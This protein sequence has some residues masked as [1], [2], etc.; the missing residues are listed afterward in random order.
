MNASAVS[1]HSNNIFINEASLQIGIT[2]DTIG[3]RA[4][5]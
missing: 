4:N 2:D 1:V 3:Q 5:I